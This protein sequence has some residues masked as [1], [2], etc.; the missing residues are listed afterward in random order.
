MLVPDKHCVLSCQA[1]KAAALSY[2][3]SMQHVQGV[4]RAP[5]TF[6]YQMRWKK[7]LRGPAFPCGKGPLGQLE[8]P[9]VKAL[10]RVSPAQVLYWPG[11]TWA[12]M[13]ASPCRSQ[14]LGSCAALAWVG[15]RRFLKGH[16]GMVTAVR[17]CL[18]E[19]VPQ[20]IIREIEQGCQLR[21]L[22]RG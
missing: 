15:M 13:T 8:S 22:W 17:A 4:G 9:V 2:S 20:L 14:L 10:M 18:C 3:D 6:P 7:L 5:R 19:D 21:H 1:H 12:G 16:T 11:L